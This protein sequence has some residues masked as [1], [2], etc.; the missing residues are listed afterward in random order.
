MST[1]EVPPPKKKRGRKPK[2]TS[3]PQAKQNLSLNDHINDNMIIKLQKKNLDIESK[4]LLPGYIKDNTCAIEPVQL[5]KCWNCNYH[6]KNSEK[7]IPL[8]YENNIFYIY[9]S[10]CCSSCSLRFI[11]DNFQNKELWSKYE[12]FNL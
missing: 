5:K 10:F 8:K 7:S 2:N 4:E 12:L 11:L 9:G 6:I 3:Q 1:T